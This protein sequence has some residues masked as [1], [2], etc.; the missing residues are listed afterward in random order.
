VSDVSDL[1]AV[2]EFLFSVEKDSTIIKW[3]IL[4]GEVI[5]SFTTTLSV[6]SLEHYAG[7]LYAGLGENSYSKFKIE[8]GSLIYSLRGFFS[9]ASIVRALCCCLQCHC[10]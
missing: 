7:L 5:W 3:K 6:T 9:L 8:N 10:L 2:G 4:T 1:L